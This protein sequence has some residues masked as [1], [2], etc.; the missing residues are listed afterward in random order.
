MPTFADTTNHVRAG[1][2]SGTGADLLIVTVA[3]DEDAFRGADFIPSDTRL[4]LGERA[5]IN[6][7]LDWASTSCN[8]RL[9]GRLRLPATKVAY[10]D[11][12]LLHEEL[13][14]VRRMCERSDASGL[15]VYTR[16]RSA[17]VRA[18]MC[19]SRRL[20]LQTS[21]GELETGPDGLILRFTQTDRP[22][23]TAISSWTLSHDATTVVSSDG[24]NELTGREAVLLQT[25]G[26]GVSHAEVRWTP[27][28]QLAAP[29]LEFLYEA[30]ERAG[31]QGSGMVIR[32]ASGRVAESVQATR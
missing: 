27:L 28:R 3:R 23:L 20:Q 6:A 26:R 17:P 1:A 12:L 14:A 29:L 4:L 18:L 16:D 31:E 25:L 21:S 11:A 9:L 24:T 10:H 30:S 19:D 5:F 2:L 8:T 32:T 22:A 15:G 7:F 13:R